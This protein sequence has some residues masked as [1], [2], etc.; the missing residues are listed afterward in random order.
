MQADKPGSVFFSFD[1]KNTCHLSSPNLTDGVNRSTHSGFPVP[2][3]IK[4]GIGRA[5]LGPEPI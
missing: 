5:A 4:T 1:R 3:A 2:T